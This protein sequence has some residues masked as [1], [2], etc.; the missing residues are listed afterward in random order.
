MQ[1]LTMIYQRLLETWGEVGFY[2]VDITDGA[3]G[4]E[5]VAAIA[6]QLKAQGDLPDALKV[7]GVI[8]TPREYNTWD[9]WVTDAPRPWRWNAVYYRIAFG[10]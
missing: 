10:A 6:D 1:E 8:C 4:P 9:T 3:T 7:T 2:G 5:Q